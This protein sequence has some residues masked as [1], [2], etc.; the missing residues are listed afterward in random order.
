MVIC[1]N[2]IYFQKN[3]RQFFIQ[4]LGNCK[5]SLAMKVDLRLLNGTIEKLEGSGTGNVTEEFDNIDLAFEIFKCSF[6]MKTCERYPMPAFTDMCE[7]LILKNQFYTSIFEAIKPPFKCP[8]Q[9]G[10]YKI[11]FLSFEIPSVL[12]FIPFEGNTWV[13]TF[14]FIDQKTRKVQACLSCEVK[15]VRKRIRD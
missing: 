9:P 12:S 14:K 1:N 11:D 3:V 10:N 2:E 13:A 6:D 7:K 15:V 5:K 8:V 4:K